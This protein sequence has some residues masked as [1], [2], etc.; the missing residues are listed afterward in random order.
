[1]KKYFRIATMAYLTLLGATLGAVLYAGIVVAPVTFHTERWLGEGVLSHFQMGLIMT[2][3]FV[4]LSYL[5][6]VTMI[7]VFLYEGYKYKQF[8]RDKLTTV[9]ALVVLMSGALFNWYYLPD[10]ITMQMAGEAMTRSEVFQNVHKASEI[11]F[12]IF[13]AAILVLMVQNMRKA[14]K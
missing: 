14:C 12:K 5:V 3:N 7:S 10:I 13:A 4:G 9:A 6:T 11:D 1:M 2:Q 8:E